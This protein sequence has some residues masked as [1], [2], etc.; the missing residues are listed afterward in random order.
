MIRIAASLS[1]LAA[2]VLA[3]EPLAQVPG[4]EWGPCIDGSFEVR[5]TGEAPLTGSLQAA[6][7]Q[8]R[9][10][11]TRRFVREVCPS[12]ISRD[13]EVL[14]GET[15]TRAVSTVTGR[16]LRRADCNVRRLREVGRDVSGETLRLTLALSVP[17]CG[18]D[19]RPGEDP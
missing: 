10:A 19:A 15:S 3:A 18:P 14:A 11:A 2:P 9:L 1:V 6:A 12:T 17:A 5:A 8:A 13:Q 4:I 7:A 16:T